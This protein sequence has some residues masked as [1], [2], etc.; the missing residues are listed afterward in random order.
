MPV[1]SSLRLPRYDPQ[2]PEP[3]VGRDAD[4]RPQ[5]EPTEKPKTPKGRAKKRILYA[6]S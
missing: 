6:A 2:H 4:P 1:R 5:V 3:Q